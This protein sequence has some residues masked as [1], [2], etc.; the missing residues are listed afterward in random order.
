MTL[1]FSCCDLYFKILKYFSVTIFYRI[2]PFE[3]TKHTLY[4]FYV[5]NPLFKITGIP[6]VNFDLVILIV[7][8]HINVVCQSLWFQLLG[9]PFWSFL[10]RFHWRID[11]S[12]NIFFHLKV[13][14][15]KRLIYIKLIMH[16]I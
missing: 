14:H 5:I 6:L 3:R 10:Q 15:F 11:I 2:T 8:K 12:I 4:F 9:I 1:C 7:I 13:I 16:E